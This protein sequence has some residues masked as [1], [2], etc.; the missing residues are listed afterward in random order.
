MRQGDESLGDSGGLSCSR[1]LRH[2]DGLCRR[3]SSRL[4]VL[5]GLHL[6]PW[7]YTNQCT[8]LKACQAQ[9]HHQV[10]RVWLEGEHP[11][12]PVLVSDDEEGE[13]AKLEGKHP[14]NPIVISDDE[15]E[16]RPPVI[17]PLPSPEYGDDL[18]SDM[19][20]AEI[21]RSLQS[22]VD[23]S[24]PGDEWVADMLHGIVQQVD[25]ILDGADMDEDNEY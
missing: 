12:N 18:D 1:S 11:S 2:G 20:Y 16:P 6:L 22:L 14:S 4:L 17:T 24:E 9:R 8:L 21:A 3:S 19:E 13:D 5:R 10:P 25:D 7:W 15:E 23:N